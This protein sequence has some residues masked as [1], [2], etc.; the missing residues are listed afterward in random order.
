MLVRVDGASGKS[1]RYDARS[2]MRQVG[3][4]ESCSTGGSV[5]QNSGRLGETAP[6]G[7]TAPKRGA[8]SVECREVEL[9]LVV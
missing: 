3:C 4:G 6:W 1:G 9:I 8:R 2:K 5:R 7:E